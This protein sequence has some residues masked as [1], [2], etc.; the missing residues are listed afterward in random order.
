M[1]EE[2]FYQK[3]EAATLDVNIFNHSNHVKMAWIYVQRFELPEA[4][5][6][7]SKALRNFAVANGAA[8]LYHETITFAYLILINERLH[9]HKGQP[10]WDE[11]V[12]NNPDLFDWKNNILKKFYREE[13]I[14]SS[15]AKKI[16]V[17]P[18]KI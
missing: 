2:E 17:F 4:M 10:T 3:F 14:K 13:T 16:F 5:A 11:F 12:Q 18:D 8:N 1:T 6:R 7:F 15:F 9:L